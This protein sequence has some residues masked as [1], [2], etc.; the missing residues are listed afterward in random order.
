MK[1]SRLALDLVLALLVGGWI[2][3][4]MFGVPPAQPT[5]G[6]WAQKIFYLHVP[7]AMV[8]YLGVVI[9]AVCSIGFLATENTRWDSRLQSLAEVSFVF[10]TLVLLT[11]PFWARPVWGVW[12]RWEPRLTSFL[13]LWVMLGA[14]FLFRYGLPHGHQRRV[15][16]S[17][18]ALLV[19]INVPIVHLSVT[20][21]QPE[22]QLHPMQ[23]SLSP[24]MQY[25]L[26][27]S[28][29]MLCLIFAR[30]VWLRYEIES[31][32]RRT[33]EEDYGKR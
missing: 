18:Y 33:L 5:T 26:Y 1:R 27:V 14:Y 19:S 17:I 15:Y 8:T 31:Y 22:Q 3:W 9:T 13:I 32:V 7:S 2:G 10:A 20:F 12:W 11:G 16:S 21:W 28:L 30:L 4:I 23:I 25:T 6:A 24:V 29:L